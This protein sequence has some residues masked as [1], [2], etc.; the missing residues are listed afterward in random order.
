M[1]GKQLGLFKAERKSLKDKRSE[2]DIANLEAAEIILQERDRY[3]GDESL[4]V[5]WAEMIIDRLV[6]VEEPEQ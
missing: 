3:G 2:A 4:M 6:P 5:R 1:A